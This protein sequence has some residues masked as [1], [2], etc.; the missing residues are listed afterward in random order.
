MFQVSYLALLV[1]GR[2]R[3]EYMVQTVHVF[4]IIVHRQPPCVLSCG[5][6][7]VHDGMSGV[8]CEVLPRLEAGAGASMS[9]FLVAPV[10]KLIFDVLKVSIDTMVGDLAYDA[11]GLVL[12]VIYSI[13]SASSSE[14][15][16]PEGLSI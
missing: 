12:M 5:I 14:S 6:V 7:V 4:Y 15:G 3:T 9:V 16:L 11:A 8:R 1:R 10:V 13:E 2:G